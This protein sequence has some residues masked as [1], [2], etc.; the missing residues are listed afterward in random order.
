M[1]DLV[2]P[3]TTERES[4]HDA[5]NQE[6]EI[7]KEKSTRNNNY[8]H[9]SHNSRSSSASSH[10][11]QSS[12]D[13][14]MTSE[15]HIEQ[16]LEKRSILRNN[17]GD[18]DNRVSSAREALEVMKTLSNIEL[19]NFDE[20]SE[21]DDVDGMMKVLRDQKSYNKSVISLMHTR[22]SIR[23][24]EFTEGFGFDSSRRNALDA[25]RQKAELGLKV[26][27]RKTTDDLPVLKQTGDYIFN[28][29]L[30]MTT[31]KKSR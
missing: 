13:E 14:S 16:L 12:D 8:C 7:L 27:Y 17:R 23:N 22:D 9:F 3:L 10:R 1:Q 6:N 5:P 21:P 28:F 18:F 30:I 4:K 19:E 24:K 2:T 25:A 15:K 29:H 26:D 31:S 20:D 11:E